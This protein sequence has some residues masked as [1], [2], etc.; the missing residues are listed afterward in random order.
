MRARP[1]LT[2]LLLVGAALLI[3]RSGVEAQD[4][5]ALR[6]EAVR[7]E[8][9][10]RA[11]V[12]R[13]PPEADA[14]ARSL[15]AGRRAALATVAGVLACGDTDRAEREWA[16][17]VRAERPDSARAM[18][19]LHLLLR[20]AVRESADDVRFH[21]EKLE[22]LNAASAALAAQAAELAEAS[23]TLAQRGDRASSVEVT[24]RVT[25][26]DATSL[27]RFVRANRAAACPRSSEAVSLPSLQPVRS[28]VHGQVAVA[29]SLSEL[30]QR[31]SELGEDGQLAQL[32]LQ[33]ALARAQAL[34]TM[35]SEMMKAMHDAI[36]ALIQNIGKA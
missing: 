26:D 1:D 5:D 8:A 13:A 22:A 28:E 12:R 25:A 6:A 36:M 18:N 31:L 35:M 20:E 19:L 17:F 15:E 27:A 11:E 2:A 21:L 4:P 9:A 3:P 10:L 32:D 23:R 33:N 29:H 7:T 24:E 34:V 16:A 30:E 14:A